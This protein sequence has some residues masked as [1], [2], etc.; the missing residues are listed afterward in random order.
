MADATTLKFEPFGSAVDPEFWHIF[1]KKKLHEYKLDNSPKEIFGT[2]QIGG[3]Y[4]E[5][6]ARIR[7]G[8]EAYNAH[9]TYVKVPY[10]IFI[11]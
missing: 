2:Y 8:N 11:I 1:E 4:A 10:S 5:I 7:I 9:Q 3:Q 6:K